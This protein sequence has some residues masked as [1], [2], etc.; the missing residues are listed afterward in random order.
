MIACSYGTVPVVRNV[1]GLHDTI[2][3]YPESD[4]NG[5]R[6]D[7]YNAHEFLSAIRASLDVYSRSAEWSKLR[8]RAKASEFTWD[9]SAKEYF[10]IYNYLIRD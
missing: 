7:C 9:N 4:S 3:P 8:K 2:K 1:G 10:G 5:F 6:F